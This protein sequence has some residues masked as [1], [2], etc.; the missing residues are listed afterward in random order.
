MNKRSKAISKRN[1]RTFSKKRIIILGILF[2]I[3]GLIIYGGVNALKSSN[4]NFLTPARNIFLKATYSPN[5]GFLFTSQS[6]GTVKSLN[7]G[8]GN[9]GNLG[10]DPT[11]T[12]N[13]GNVLSIH[14]INEDSMKHSKHNLK[15]CLKCTQKNHDAI[16]IRHFYGSSNR[17]IRPNKQIQER[18]GKYSHTKYIFHIKK[19]LL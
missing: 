4:G 9:R 10:H 18:S 7:S 14:V 1:A 15:I 6:T 3:G 8:A 13:Q 11:I 12:L 2:T 5:A 19:Y 17:S 16:L